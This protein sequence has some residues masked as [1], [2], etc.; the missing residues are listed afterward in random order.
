MLCLPWWIGDAAFAGLWLRGNEMRFAAPD[1]LLLC[2][3]HL[4]LNRIDLA[5]CG[6]DV[7][8]Q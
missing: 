3:L 4:S 6:I 8:R 7:S 1:E 2:G 5:I